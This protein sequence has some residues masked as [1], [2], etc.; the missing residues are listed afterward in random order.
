MMTPDY[1]KPL[2]DHYD[3]GYL[4]PPRAWTVYAWNYDMGR[5]RAIISTTRVKDAID[6]RNE[7]AGSLNAKGIENHYRIN[8]SRSY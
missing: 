3:T 6:L 8:K 2:P 7:L 1:K 4:I 5:W